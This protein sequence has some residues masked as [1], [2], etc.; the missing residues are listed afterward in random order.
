MK[1]SN[2]WKSSFGFTALTFVSRVFGYIRDLMFSSILGANVVHDIFVVIFKIPNVFRSFFGEG[3]LAQS[4]TPSIIEAKENLH[5]FLNQIFTVL[6]SVLAAFV[7]FVMLFPSIFVSIFAP[8]FISDEAKFLAASQFLGY[9]FPYILLISLVAFLGAVQNSRKKFQVVAATP[10]LFNLTLI[11]FACFAED[12][13]L[14]VIGASVILAGILQLLLNLF[15]TNKLGYFPSFTKQFEN[16]TLNSFFARFF[17]AILAAGVYQLNVLVDTIFASFL[18]SGSPTWLYLSDR[19]IQFP[20]GLFGVAIALVALPDLTEQLVN[21]NKK[22]F[23]KVFYKGFLSTFLLGLLSAIFYVLLS[24][25]VIQLLFFR[26]EF[27]NYDVE[28]TSSSLIAYSYALPFLLSY[29]FFN[30][31]FFAA[32]KTKI[33]L[34][35]GTISLIMNLVL[36]YLFIFSYDWGHV[37]LA[38]ATTFAAITVWLLAVIL[39]IKMFSKKVI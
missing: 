7:L 31:V 1:L 27:T 29:K 35:L 25:Q 26:G 21:K 17:P 12:L 10:I 24:Y 38:L 28:M 22:E 4:L 6:F 34:M 8:G 2:F 37:G 32:S 18:I 11:G 39:I 5:A 16:K 9:V 14:K 36:N 13:T 19:L 15:V 30:S 33:V 20:M 3:A 23:T